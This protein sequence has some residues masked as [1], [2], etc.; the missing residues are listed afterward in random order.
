MPVAHERGHSFLDAMVGSDRQEET[1]SETRVK[2]GI[3]QHDAVLIAAG[4]LGSTLE[5]L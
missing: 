1:H 4:A 5:A 3:S 2:G